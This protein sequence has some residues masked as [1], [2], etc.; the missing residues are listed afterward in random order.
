M[1]DILRRPKL[2]RFV[3]SP[4]KAE[5][6]RLFD[7]VDS[8]SVEKRELQL[9]VFSVSV[10][11]V[12][13]A[14]LAVLMYP[15]IETHPVLFSARTLK[16]SFLGF[17]GLSVLLI[18]YLV[19]RQILV[20]R[21]R[22][23]VRAAEARFSELHKQ[24]GK[25]LLDALS[26]MNHFQDRLTME[27]RRAVN[28]RDTLSVMVVRLTP[29]ANLG[30]PADV[31]AALGDA[32]KAISRRLRREDS[33]YHFSEGAFGIMLPGVNVQ[34]AR[35]VTARLAEGLHD[36]SGALERFSHDIKIFNYPQHAATASELEKAVRELLPAELI[37]EPSL[38]D[39]FETQRSSRSRERSELSKE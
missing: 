30:N 8:S 29:N 14:G 27:F 37:S 12:L 15:S 25:D 17:C 2:G 13:M 9:A 21:L 24:V 32:V 20:H 10:I 39:V 16:I 1:G 3:H 19:D 11:A 7:R 22:H 34:N 33:L 35:I 4:K 38:A 26:G 18:G 28:T 31:T 36:V 23:D 6:V 5:P